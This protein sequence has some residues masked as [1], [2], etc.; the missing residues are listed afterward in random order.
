MGIM[1]IRKERSGM[2][3]KLLKQSSPQQWENLAA[4]TRGCS[5]TRFEIVISSHTGN[6]STE[7]SVMN[8]LFHPLSYCQSGYVDRNGDL[9]FAQGASQPGVAPCRLVE[10]T[11]LTGAFHAASTTRACLWTEFFGILDDETRV[12]KIRDT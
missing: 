6:L 12:E 1:G 10:C 3:R 2:D 4:N 5:H 7:F 9:E 11:Q 8:A